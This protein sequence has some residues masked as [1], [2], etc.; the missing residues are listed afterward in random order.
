M[1][2]AQLES[3][4]YPLG[5]YKKPEN[6]SSKDI[7]GYIRV[8]EEFPQKIR[9]AT[10]GLNDTELT[11]KHRPEGWM[12]RQLVHHLADSHMTAFTRVKLALTE[13][14][15]TVKPY[16]E[17]EWVKLPDT[18]QAPIEWSLMIIEGVHNRLVTVLRSLNKEQLQKTYF[19]PEYQKLYTISDVILLYSWHCGHHM[20][21]INQALK[22]KNIF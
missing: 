10:K 18:T 1:E 20:A 5:K 11:Y 12:V 4:K 2:Q 19:N 22:H 8:L 7:E 14:N 13:S 3:L 9:Q 21:H 17:N 15:P 6:V 16:I